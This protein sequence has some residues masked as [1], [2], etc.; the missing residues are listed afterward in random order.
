M[1][2]L[3]FSLGIFAL[4]VQIAAAQ[5]GLPN[6]APTD[7]ETLMAL[8]WT[9]AEWQAM[10]GAQPTRWNAQQWQVVVGR[11]RIFDSGPTT[12]IWKG[13]AAIE[14]PDGAIVYRNLIP[15][16]NIYQFTYEKQKPAQ[17]G[18]R[19]YYDIV[20]PTFWGDKRIVIGRYDITYSAIWD[21]FIEALKAWPKRDSF[22][23]YLKKDFGFDQKVFKV[24]LHSSHDNFWHYANK[25]VNTTDG[26]SGWSSKGLLTLCPLAGIMLPASDDPQVAKIIRE[27]FLY[28][29]FM[30]DVIHVS[31]HNRCDIV[32]KANRQPPFPA[33]IKDWF[34]EGIA[35]MGIVQTYPRFKAGFYRFYYDRLH[36]QRMP[37]SQANN[38]GFANYRTLGTMFLQYLSEQYGNAAIRR[39]FDTTCD[40][41]DEQ[42]AFQNAFGAPMETAYAAAHA[43][44]D[45][46]RENFEAE[47]PAMSV[48]NLPVMTAAPAAPGCRRIE[49]LSTL[50]QN[51]NQVNGYNDIP[52][53]KNAYAYNLGALRGKFE[54]TVA[55]AKPRRP[56]EKIF[57]WKGGAYAVN[58]VGW[59]AIV[60]P[61]EYQFSGANIKIINWPTKSDRQIQFP[62]GSKV[63]CWNEKS[64][65]SWND[66]AGNKLR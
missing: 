1:F 65:C 32:R 43:Y 38:P 3:K 42:T 39:F 16:V 44:W 40:G 47:Y 35:E 29:A 56:K 46:Q 31:Y 41:T 5:E 23:Q 13:S 45:A 59:Q 66:A 24:I 30:H 62:D 36:A 57:I 25:P 9:E 22:L 11:H 60:S 53:I 58:G 19:L 64:G 14:F 48:E 54:G 21:P 20:H 37:L 28:G 49:D 6:A 27:S 17:I 10:A 18:A 61:D 4:T 8:P 34:V 55:G 2:R 26:C 52:C 12:S 15:S 7:Y 63:H 33:P 51:V 50:P